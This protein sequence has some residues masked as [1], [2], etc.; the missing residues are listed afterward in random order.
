MIFPYFRRALPLLLLLLQFGGTP[1]RAQGADSPRKLRK[2]VEEVC[3]RMRNYSIV[4]DSFNWNR[5][6]REA[7]SMVRTIHSMAETRPVIAMLLQKLKDKGDRHSFFLPIE[8][9]DT[10]YR[11]LGSG[12]LP[13]ASRLDGGVVLLTVP[14]FA[15]SETEAHLRYA[16]ALQ[17]LIRE[18]DA[19][20]DVRGWIIDLRHNS[21]GS[22][23]PMIAGLNPLVPDG[24]FGY[25]LT[26]GSKD[27]TA[28]FSIGGRNNFLTLDSSYKVRNPSVPLALLIDS[29][30]GSSG[31]MT[32]LSFLGLPN[33]R[34]FGQTTAGYTTANSQFTLSDSS[35]L[36]LA[37]AY[38]ADR[39]HKIYPQGIVPDT[40]VPPAGEAV[41]Q[42]ALAW[43]RSNGSR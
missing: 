41:V 39:N 22:M 32:T 20:G 37:T 29:L 35:L 17:G 2:Y 33:V 16:A 26:P 42:A 24:N 34:T 10:I 15:A 3:N 11:K 36:F 40:Q 8:K 7:D 23:W 18:M 28:L 27:G 19:A 12:N 31:E 4:R 13:Q 5:I 6:D 25:Y 9:K 38:I 14:R 21:G 30:T 1:V 43:I